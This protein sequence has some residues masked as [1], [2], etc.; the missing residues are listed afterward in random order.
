MRF[1]ALLQEDIGSFDI[2]K[3]AEMK[4][5][6]DTLRSDCTTHRNLLEVGETNKV[7]YQPK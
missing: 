1:R 7:L 2:F 6:V 4:S 5:I 3:K